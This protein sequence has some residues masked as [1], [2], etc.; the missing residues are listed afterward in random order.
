M[1]AMRTIRGLPMI[2]GQAVAIG[3][4]SL[5]KRDM[6]GGRVSDDDAYERY[7]RHHGEAHPHEPALDRK[8]F[9][10]QER[11]R[12]WNGIRRCC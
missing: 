8:G 4:V 2:C 9:F 11:D 1:K 7:L 6:A 3:I 10:R 12:K 5:T